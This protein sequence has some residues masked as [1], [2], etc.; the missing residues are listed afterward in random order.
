M[1]FHEPHIRN[2]HIKF[3]PSAKFDAIPIKWTNKTE[4]IFRDGYLSYFANHFL[5]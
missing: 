4:A 5:A 3:S 2:L 1:E